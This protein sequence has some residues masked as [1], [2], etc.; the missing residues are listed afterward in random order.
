MPTDDAMLSVSALVAMLQRNVEAVG[1]DLW[2]QCEISAF[3]ERRHWYFTV[4][5][6]DARIGCIA[7]SSVAQSIGFT[8]E[9]GMMVRLRG[10]PTVYVKEGRLQFIVRHMVPVGEGA[11]HRAFEALKARL[12]R[13]GLFD[14]TRKREL[15]PYPAVIG[16]VT[17]GESAAYR[18]IVKVIGERFPSVRLVLQSVRVQGVH[19]PSEIAD[20]IRAFGDLPPEHPQRPDVLIVGRGGGAAEDLW[21]F[22]EEEVARAVFACPIPIISGVGHETDH[23]I[24]DLVADRRAATPSNA[25]ETAVPMAPHLRRAVLNFVQSGRKA[26]ESRAQYSR[27]FVLRT[28]ESR[29]FNRPGRLLND[30]RQDTD[31]L[32]DQLSFGVRRRVAAVRAQTEALQGRIKALDPTRVLGLGYIR[33]ER[34]GQRVRRSDELQ[35]GNRVSLHFRDGHNRA[36]IIAEEP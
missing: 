24:T 13:E 2:M 12:Q 30:A 18:D 27:L 35:V 32:T 16:L 1:Q 36:E 5:D 8:P 7:W 23:T 11:L 19:A 17:S 15:P 3:T 9:V 6:S 29:R 26:V 25:A 20:A 10:Y 14:P 34:D 33:V 21:A 31:R 28:V 22:N 4:K